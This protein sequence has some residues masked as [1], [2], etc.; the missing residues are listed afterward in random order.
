MARLIV[1][2]GASGAGKTFM[3]SQLTNYRSDIIPIK[4]ITTRKPRKN[5]PIEESIDLK[6]AQDVNKIKRCAYTYHYCGNY[7]GIKKEEIDSIL[8]I[9]KNPIVIVA[10]CNTITKIKQDYHD[11]LIL[12]VNSGLSGEDLKSQLLKHG[13]PIDVDERMKRQKMDLMI[14]FNI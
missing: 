9:D 11:A 12:Y 6:F 2:A 3:L 13:D 8:K 4:K 7:Y 10:N 1:V 14:I 5:E